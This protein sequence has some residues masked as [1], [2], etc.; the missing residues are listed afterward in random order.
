V[1]WNS[2]VLFCSR[3]NE[4]EIWKT[5]NQKEQGS[6]KSYAFRGQRMK[7]NSVVANKFRCGLP[8]KWKRTAWIETPSRQ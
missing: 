2:M 6:L 7:F 1:V 4:G 5:E 3:D 8:Q